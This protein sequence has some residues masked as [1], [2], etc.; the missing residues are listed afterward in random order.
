MPRT[1]AWFQLLYHS[2]PSEEESELLSLRAASNKALRRRGPKVSSR[3]KQTK[4]NKASHLPIVY[5]CTA[6]NFT[7]TILQSLFFPLYREGDFMTK[8][9]FWTD[10]VNTGLKKAY[11]D[12]NQIQVFCN[13]MGNAPLPVSIGSFSL[14]DKVACLVNVA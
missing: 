9:S 7:I 10:T 4:K 3:R 8:S 13:G 1:E 11:Q 2:V 12:S 5:T 14:S 6:D